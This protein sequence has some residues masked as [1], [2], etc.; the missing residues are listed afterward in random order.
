MSPGARLCRPA[1]SRVSDFWV[2]SNKPRINYHNPGEHY[3]YLQSP[4]PRGPCAPPIFA[5]NSITP[6]TRNR[7]TSQCL[8][9][10]DSGLINH[11]SGRKNE[12]NERAGKKR[13][14]ERRR[15]SP[16]SDPFVVD[17]LSIM[18]ANWQMARC[19]GWNS[20]IVWQNS[21]IRRK[22]AFFFFFFLHFRLC[23]Q[24]E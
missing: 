5:I 14:G 16:S 6:R 2:S 18:L 7:A 8:L 23:F 12:R 3:R 24:Q 15:R 10:S 19:T 22:G 11:V 1:H 17:Y 13:G 21:F 9:S 4:H 20:D